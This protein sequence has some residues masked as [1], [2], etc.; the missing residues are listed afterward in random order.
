LKK[1]GTEKFWKKMGNNYELKGILGIRD[2]SW[3]VL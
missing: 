1:V 3:R 2:S